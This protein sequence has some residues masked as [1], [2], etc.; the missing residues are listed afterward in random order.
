MNTTLGAIARALGVEVSASHLPVTG[1]CTDSRQITPGNVFLAL[2]GETFDGHQFVDQAAAAGAIALIVEAPVPSPLPQLQ[3][4][5]TLTAYQ[6]L[7]QW[8]RQQCPANVIAVTGSV[9]K[10]TT[11]EMIAAVLSHY[12]AVLKT[13]ANFNNE[14]GVPKTLLQLEPH[15]QFAVIEMGMRARGEIA[16][17][18]Q[19]AQPDVA[20]ITNVGTAHIGRLGSR[21][22]IAQA[23]CELLAEMPSGGAAVLNADSPLLLSTAAQVWSGHTITYGLEGGT[24]RGIYQP[25]QTLH[26]DER[27]YTVPLAGAHHAL[28]FLAALGVLQAL[29][30]ESDRLPSQ[31]TLE[32]PSGRGGRYRLEPDI[33]LLDETYNAGLESMVAALH[34]LRSLPGRRHLAVLGP[35]RELGDFSI[36]FHEQV[37]A[38][39]AQLELDALLILD[40]GVEGAALARGAGRVPTQQFASHEELVDYL[41]REL[42]AG[43]RLLFKASHAVA[44]DRVVTDLRQRWEKICP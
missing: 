6:R 39:V 29:G 37:G 20:V 19:I 24:L 40:R 26:V 10:T 13:E 22:A 41:L 4:P 16:L 32:L 9:G 5:N 28:N 27:T 7:G 34:L 2:R 1:I 43:D 42:K 23:K 36:A 25:P 12:G 21:E 38:T 3:V 14:I 35:M 31:L 8:W 44:L 11:K 18:S 17:L 15:H 30:L 33:L